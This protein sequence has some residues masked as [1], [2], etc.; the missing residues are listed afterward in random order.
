MVGKCRHFRDFVP[1]AEFE[2]IIPYLYQ[3]FPTADFAQFMREEQ[4][5]KSRAEFG[6]SGNIEKDVNEMVRLFSST[7]HDFEEM[8]QKSVAS[9]IV[10]WNRL[11]VRPK[12][13]DTLFELKFPVSNDVE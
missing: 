4:L 2:V 5:V 7:S 12:D 11:V 8:L 6:R 3:M 9:V 1:S 13:F 10:E